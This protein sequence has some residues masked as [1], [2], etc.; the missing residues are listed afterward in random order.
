MIM[1][2]AIYLYSVIIDSSS[3]N[4]YCVV[5]SFHTHIATCCFLL[6]ISTPEL[7]HDF[8]SKEM[9]KQEEKNVWQFYCMHQNSHTFF[10]LLAMAFNMATISGSCLMSFIWRGCDRVP[11]YNSWKKTFIWYI[12]IKWK[13]ISSS[14]SKS[15]QLDG[16][17]FFAYAEQMFE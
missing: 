5:W 8:I 4:F 13:I 2:P 15:H 16:F 1:I 7:T 9:A 11:A 17:I 14:L 6:P 3:M 10:F 12:M